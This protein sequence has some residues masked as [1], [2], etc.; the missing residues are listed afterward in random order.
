[1]W[2]AV[3]VGLGNIGLGYDYGRAPTDDSFVATH[4]QAALVHPRVALV[5]GVDASADRR[6]AFVRKANAPAAP[7]VADLSVGGPVDIVCL[8]VPTALHAPIFREVVEVLRPRLVLCEKPLAPSVEQGR[9]MIEIARR[10]QVALAVNFVRRMGRGGQ[11]MHQE[12]IKEGLIGDLR[13]VRGWYSKGLLNNGSHWLDWT[14]H[15]LGSTGVE[16]GSTRLVRRLVDREDLDVD[17]DLHFPAGAVASFRAWPHERFELMEID[18]LGDRG[19]IH[20]H[21]GGVRVD[22]DLVE[23]D[24]DFPGYKIL[25]RSKKAWDPAF[26]RYQLQCLEHV[27]EYLEGRVPDLISNGETALESLVLR[28]R[29]LQQLG[30]HEH[31]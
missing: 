7:R 9:A 11:L 27:V 25:V 23:D 31:G 12:L 6:S 2:S 18:F 26:E 17:F 29:I 5:G 19:R 16:V 3:V 22:V 24:P 10:A 20:C 1:M 15:L 4:T 8:A 21:G 14:L 13:R 30:E 28:Q